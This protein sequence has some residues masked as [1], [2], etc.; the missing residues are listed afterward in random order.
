MMLSM[1]L[2]SLVRIHHTYS[3]KT[4]LNLIFRFE[5]FRDLEK[6]SFFLDPYMLSIDGDKFK[7]Y[8]T[9]DC[10][11]RIALVIALLRKLGAIKPNLKSTVVFIANEEKSTT[12][13][14]GGDTLVKDGLF[15]KLKERSLFWDIATNKQ[16]C[17]GASGMIPWKLRITGK[18]FHHRLAQNDMNLLELAMNAIQEIKLQACLRCNSKI[19]FRV[20]EWDFQPTYSNKWD[21]GGNYCATCTSWFL[22]LKQWDPGGRPFAR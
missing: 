3:D 7:G 16:P 15:N 18:L 21:P 20:K 10:L 4:P 11:G 14:V 22:C 19:K 1:L 13:G 8:G 6:D 12:I 2:D 9:I 5:T 17:V